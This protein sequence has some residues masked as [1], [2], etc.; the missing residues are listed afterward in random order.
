MTIDELTA[1]VEELTAQLEAAQAAAE[2]WKK[3]SRKHEDRAKEN[4]EAAERVKELEAKL[5]ETGTDTE[6]LARTVEDLKAQVA[7]GEAARKNAEL[8][9]LKVRIG[10]EKGLPPEFTG[11]VQGDDEESISADV[12]ALVAAIP[13]VA[14]QQW[15]NLPHGLSGESTTTQDPLLAAVM[16]KIGK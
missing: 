14:G 9:A 5:A 1:K 8:T 6:K 3:H 11:R 10:A 16:S 15:P 12:D 13:N 2:N 4:A 7:E